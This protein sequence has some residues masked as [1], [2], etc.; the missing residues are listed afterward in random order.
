MQLEIKYMRMSTLLTSTESWKSKDSLR[1]GHDGSSRT[2]VIQNILSSGS[3]WL[4]K[5]RRE[6]RRW[7]W[8]T[9]LW[10]VLRHHMFR[11]FDFFSRGRWRARRG[12]THRM[13]W[14]LR[15]LR[16]QEH[17]FIRRFAEKWRFEWD[18]LELPCSAVQCMERR[19]RHSALYCERT[20]EKLDYNIG[21]FNPCWVNIYSWSILRR[22]VRDNN[23]LTHVR[24]DFWIVCYGG[25]CRRFG[26][27]PERI[28]IEADP[29]HA[30]LLIKKSG[31]Q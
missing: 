27:A 11:D 13:S 28:D 8:R 14:S 30:E 22:W 26:K 2:R 20:M 18:H 5:R 9:E 16:S 3:D 25:L 24:Y 6:Q 10:Q 17:I 23:S 31:L 12:G 7:I 1:L 29:R 21:V 4:L 19:T 15:S